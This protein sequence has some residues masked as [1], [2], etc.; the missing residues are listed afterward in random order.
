MKIHGVPINLADAEAGPSVESQS[1][2]DARQ[3]RERE[4]HR[5][6][7]QRHA[8]MIDTP[9][10]LDV[11]QDTTRRPWNGYWTSYDMLMAQQL[12]GKKVVVSGC[13]F[14]DDA[15]R[16]GLLGAA[17][18]A[19]DLSPELLEIARQRALRMKAPGIEFDVMPAE[20]L[21]YPDGFADVVYFNDI[22]H[23]VDIPAALAEA[24]RVL[25]PDGV[26]IANELY[27]HSLLQRIRNSR[28]VSQ[29]LYGRLVRFIY[30]GKEPYITEDERKIDES[31]LVLLQRSLKPGYQQAFF[32]VL[33]GRLLPAHWRSVARFDRALLRIV[34]PL[35]PL[36]AARVV[37]SGAVAR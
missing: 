22:L 36:L 2:L 3:Q 28:F 29:W 26:I 19:S 12:A 4:Y 15:I 11:I 25:K 10:P 31:E 35:A 21:A 23:H 37:V 17:V 9:V 1:D 18:Y 33:G 30:G 5:D 13:G 7:A 32:L 34:G 6:F 16:M 24:R 27:T 14:G 8:G 20:K